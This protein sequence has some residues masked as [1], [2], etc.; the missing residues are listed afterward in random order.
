MVYSGVKKVKVGG[1]TKTLLDSDLKAA[2]ISRFQFKNGDVPDSAWD[3]VNAAAKER[4]G[5]DFGLKSP[6]GK[7][8]ARQR[9]AKKLVDEIDKV[10]A[11][12]SDQKRFNLEIGKNS[13]YGKGGDFT[14]YAA[15][16]YGRERNF[17]PDGSMGSGSGTSKGLMIQSIEFSRK[18]QGKGL[19][20]EFI[21]EYQSRYPKRGV[22]V[23]Q[24]LNNKLAAKLER[25]SNNW[26]KV[27]GWTPDSRSYWLPPSS[28]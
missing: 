25:P 1:K 4:T 14:P 12:R 5:L 13:N 11:Q 22:F 24:V 15:R 17:K 28:S 21:G 7:L 26:Q 16:L 18:M 8:T 9:A 27:P 6:T 23:E 2:G 10:P 3:D 20:D 19:F